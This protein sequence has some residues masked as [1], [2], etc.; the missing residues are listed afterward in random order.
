MPRWARQSWVSVGVTHTMIAMTAFVGTYVLPNPIGLSTSC[1]G[2]RYEIRI[3]RRRLVLALPRVD[4]QQQRPSC[5]I[6]PKV[7]NLPRRR[8]SGIALDGDDPGWGQINSWNGTTGLPIAGGWLAKVGLLTTVSEPIEYSEYLYGLGTPSSP[9]VRQLYKSIDGWFDLLFTW[10]AVV[11]GQDTHYREPLR[12]HSVPGQGLTIQAV[13]RDGRISLPR[14]ANEMEIV[15]A[16][17][18]LVN[19]TTLRGLLKRT[20]D[21][22]IPG[23][24]RLLLRDGYVDLRRGRLRKAV[25]DGGSASESA[26]ATWCLANNVQ[27]PA[28]PTLGW[29]VLNSGAPIPPTSKTDLVDLRNDAIHKGITPTYAQASKALAVSEMIVNAT[30]SL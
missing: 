29:F 1:F 10:I 17:T 12:S 21:G 2:K 24:A 13:L 25:I 22:D 27:L 6:Q 15:V 16:K 3:Q 30:E 8:G 11:V 26:L 14:S 9:E 28:K 18:E 20:S 5:L 4:G 7:D 23:D 19:L